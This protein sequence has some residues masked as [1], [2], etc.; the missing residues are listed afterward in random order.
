MTPMFRTVTPHTPLECPA[1][2]DGSTRYHSYGSYCSPPFYSI[3][4]APHR[5]IMQR[6]GPND[7]LVSVNSAR[8]GTYEGT[9]VGV[10]HLGTIGWVNRIEYV[11]R[12]LTGKNKGQ[13]DALDFYCRIAGGLL[14]CSNSAQSMS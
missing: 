12:R 6:E 9:L 7:G 3:W 10:N 2:A 13:F 14:F 11:F 5:V 8:W 4:W 1:G